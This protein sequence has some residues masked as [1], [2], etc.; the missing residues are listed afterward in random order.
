MLETSNLIELMKGTTQHATES[1]RG[2]LDYSAGINHVKQLVEEVE[3]HRTRVG[4]LAEAQ[5]LHSEQFKQLHSCEKDARQVSE[6]T[7]SLFLCVL[8]II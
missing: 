3:N 1:G 5:K 7:Q 2:R 8:S 6:L 4:Q